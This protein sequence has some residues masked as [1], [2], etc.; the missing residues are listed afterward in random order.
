ML[1]LVQVRRRGAGFFAVMAAAAALGLA[2][3]AKAGPVNLVANGSF[4]TGDFTAWTEGGNFEATEVVSGPFYDYAGPEDGKFYAI[5]GPVGADGTL[6]Q[7]LNTAIGQTYTFSFYFA[8]V[9]DS[10]ADF[11]ASLG[12]TTFLSLTN[13]NTG[14]GYTQYSYDY[15]ATSTS[16]DL[17][18]A[19]RDD[20]AYLALDNVYVGVGAPVGPAV[21][22]SK[23][24]MAGLLALPALGLWTWKRRGRMS[25][26]PV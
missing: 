23:T 8:S 10:T 21:P 1:H 15:T 24:L 5:L 11:S 16:T 22:E 17:E 26:I 13:P 7:A 19:F 2:G 12:G 25:V 18:F 20:P 3:V 9:G 6:S 14:S 4:E